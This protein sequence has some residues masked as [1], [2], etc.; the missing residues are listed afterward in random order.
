MRSYSDLEKSLL[1]DFQHGFPLS[2][3]PFA[4]LAEKLGSDEQSVLDAYRRLQEEGV[5]SRIGPVFRPN[6]IGVST[7]AAMA[8]PPDEL[9]RVA[10][11]ISARAEINHNYER[12]HAFNLW[13]VVTARDETR[14]Q[15]ALQAIERDCGYPVM[16]L[17]MLEDYFIDLGFEI[18][19]EE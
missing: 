8:V 6:R 18:L 12:L 17:P 10:A 7:L 3:R 4:E 2:S 5:V 19:W 14:L 16:S 11:C 1:N 9:E 15:A 13:F